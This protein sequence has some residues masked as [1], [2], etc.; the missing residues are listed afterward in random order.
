MKTFNDGLTASKYLIPLVK[1]IELL[2]G[3]A[4]VSGKFIKLLNLVFL[5]VSVNIVLTHVFLA[6]EGLPVALFVFLANVF[7]IYRYWNS[8]KGIVSAN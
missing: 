1:I 6:P 7:L 4:F 5:P 8:Y 3:L 2:A